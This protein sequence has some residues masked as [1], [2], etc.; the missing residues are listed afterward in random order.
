MYR[1]LNP[2]TLGD[3]NESTK[4]HLSNFY[5]S[6]LVLLITYYMKQFNVV[7]L[8]EIGLI[9]FCPLLVKKKRALKNTLIKT[10]LALLVVN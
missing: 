5:Q 6:D 2:L 3:L 7:Y 1:P 9:G 4:T 10:R 8:I